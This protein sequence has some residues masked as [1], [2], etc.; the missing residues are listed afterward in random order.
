MFEDKCKVSI[1]L[2][3][4]MLVYTFS[5]IFYLIVTWRIGTPFKNMLQDEQY[6]N[7]RNVKEEEVTKRSVIFYQGVFISIVVLILWKPFKKC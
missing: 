5:S 4:I 6:E 3:Y 7:L 1:I 2:A